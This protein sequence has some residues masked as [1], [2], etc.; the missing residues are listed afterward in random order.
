MTVEFGN[1]KICYIVIPTNDVAAS[2]RFY[3]TV[4]G[5][6]TKIRENGDIAFDDGV[7]QVSGTWVLG[8][9]PAEDHTGLDLSIMVDDIE[10]TLK[11]IASHGCVITQPVGA[12]YP[13]LTAHFRDPGGNLIGLYQHRG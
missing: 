3:E 2:A 1:G 4:F 10:A 8:R 11:L 12:D 13:E 9:K 6:T 7:G 5:W